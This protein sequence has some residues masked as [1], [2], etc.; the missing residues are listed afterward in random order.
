[1][2]FS[3]PL[4]QV[5]FMLTFLSTIDLQNMNISMFLMSIVRQL[6]VFLIKLLKQRSSS[7][8]TF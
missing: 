4:N 5:S 2:R 7:M 3:K 6:V 8:E 1:M